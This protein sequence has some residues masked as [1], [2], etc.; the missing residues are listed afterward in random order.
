MTSVLAPNSLP[1]GGLVLRFDV[2]SRR[3][4]PP[5]PSLVTCL[6]S[7]PV[8]EKMQKTGEKLGGGANG[9]AAVAAEESAICFAFGEGGQKLRRTSPLREAN[10]WKLIYHLGTSSV[11][12]ADL[13]QSEGSSG[14]RL[15]ADRRHS[16]PSK[17]AVA[18]PAQ[19]SGRRRRSTLPRLE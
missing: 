5:P 15:A 13:S 19:I 14:R 11:S 6:S 2:A 1:L 8:I 7:R 16:G 17:R 18:S 4:P 10:C 12:S 3:P 9:F